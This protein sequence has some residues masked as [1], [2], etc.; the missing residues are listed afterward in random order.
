M[1]DI[2]TICPVIAKPRDGLLESW[3]HRDHVVIVNGEHD[4]W[5]E[6]VDGQPWHVH[7]DADRRNLGC[8]TS[9]NLGFRHARRVGARYG[10]ILSQSLVT[11]KGLR[12]LT[13]AFATVAR[14]A[15]DPAVVLSRY[16][17]H[18]I[19]IRV[20]HW[21]HLG[22]FDETLDVWCDI[23][24]LRRSWLDDEHITFTGTRTEARTERCIAVR[25]GAVSADIYELDEA[26]YIAKW[27]GPLK[28]E[29]YRRPW[30]RYSIDRHAATPARLFC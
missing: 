3:D 11:T 27:G 30:D 6:V 28:S 10:V 4:H 25:S 9:W 18:C 2:V 16:S 19:A 5:A 13:R 12:D 17:F 29:T 15:G 23:D 22:G 14:R 8:P 21:E 20:D 24:F 1:A 7:T 26:R